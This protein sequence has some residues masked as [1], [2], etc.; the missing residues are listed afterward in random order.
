MEKKRKSIPLTVLVDAEIDKIQGMSDAAIAKKNGV[1]RGALKKRQEKLSVIIESTSP[2]MEFE[3]KII[4]DVISDRLKP[5][6]EELALKSL[7]IVRQADGIVVE[8][9]TNQPKKIK[10]KDLISIS[11][12][13]SKRLARITGIEEDPGAG[14]DTPERTKFINTYTQNIF[15]IHDKKL[16]DERL[17]VN[18]TTP[19]PIYDDVSKNDKKAWLLILDMVLCY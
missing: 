18:D 19:T 11:D 10:M 4:S 9:L 14:T 16:E 7:E 8:R 5:I 1:A 17:K 12:T 13:H 15:N 3:R 2:M 6:K